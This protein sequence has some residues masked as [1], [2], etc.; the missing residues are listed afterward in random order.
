MYN[1][2]QLKLI[3]CINQSNKATTL[4]LTKTI[5]KCIHCN[6]TVING[7]ITVKKIKRQL[8]AQQ[9]HILFKSYP[10]CPGKFYSILYIDARGSTLF[11][12]FFFLFTFL[13]FQAI[14][15]RKYINGVHLVEICSIFPVAYPF[16]SRKDL[17]SN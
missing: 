8:Y 1:Q 4:L 7:K 5:W 10:R 17:I 13:I 6:C 2:Y 15:I 16:H 9:V 11:V 14:I 12:F 3:N